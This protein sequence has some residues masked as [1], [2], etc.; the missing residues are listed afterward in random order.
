MDAA[1][2]D[3]WFA[4]SAGETSLSVA[5]S[6]MR[7]DGGDPSSRKAKDPREWY[8]SF[9]TCDDEELPADVELQK[10]RCKA[11]FSCITH[12]G[13]KESQTPLQDCREGQNKRAT[14]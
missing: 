3:S 6:A 1:A 13:S 7:T 14:L 4:A 12:D 2:E 5:D 8:P 10:G 9:G 11:R